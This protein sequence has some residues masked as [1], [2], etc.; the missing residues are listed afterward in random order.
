VHG[1]IKYWVG[2]ILHKPVVNIKQNLEVHVINDHPSVAMKTIMNCCAIVSM[3]TE[4]VFQVF[5][6]TI[7]GG[8]IQS[9]AVWKTKMG[10]Q[11]VHIHIEEALFNG[12]LLRGR[13]L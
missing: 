7:H 11:L 1:P 8:D 6:I 10:E 2:Y 3:K 4:D 12:L 9:L 5:T 13:C